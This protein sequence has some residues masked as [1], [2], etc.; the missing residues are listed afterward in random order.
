MQQTDK[1]HNLSNKELEKAVAFSDR[2]QDAYSRNKMAVIAMRITP[3]TNQ[4]V[5]AEVTLPIW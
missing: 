2:L 3:M 1:N 4:L 5:L